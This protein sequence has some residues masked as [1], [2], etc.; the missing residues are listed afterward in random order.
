MG[1]MGIFKSFFPPGLAMIRRSKS[2]K[3]KRQSLDGLLLWLGP[4]DLTD[5]SDLAAERIM[6]GLPFPLRDSYRHHNGVLSLSFAKIIN[7]SQ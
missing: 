3:L 1:K 2:Q 6:G 4:A 7:Y 5:L